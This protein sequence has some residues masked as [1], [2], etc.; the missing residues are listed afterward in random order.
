M[1]KKITFEHKKELMS[2]LKKN[3]KTPEEIIQHFKDEYRVQITSELIQKT[4]ELSHSLR[5]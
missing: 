1:P 4:K 2:M 3:S 5:R